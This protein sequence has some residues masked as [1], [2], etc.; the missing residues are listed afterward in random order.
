M[1]VVA[2]PGARSVGPK[3]ETERWRAEITYSFPDGSGEFQTHFF[4]EIGELESIIELGPDWNCL[5]SCVVHLNR[6]TT[7][8]EGTER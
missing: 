6:P 5:A 2:F 8:H 7:N 4:E 1:S 3:P